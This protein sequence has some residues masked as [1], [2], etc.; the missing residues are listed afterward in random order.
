MKTNFKKG[1]LFAISV[2]TIASCSEDQDTIKPIETSSTNNLV[3]Y[4]PSGC[5]L[6]RSFGDE[7]KPRMVSIITEDGVVMQ[8]AAQR[9]GANGRYLS[10]TAGL[11]LHPADAPDLIGEFDRY[12][13]GVSGLLTVGDGSGAGINQ[14]GGRVILDFSEV[15]S[16]TMKNMLFTDIDENE[17]GSK[18][19][20]YSNAGQLLMQ[21][22]L[23]VTGDKGAAFVGFNNQPGVA[24]IIVTFG[25]ERSQHG[26]GTIARLQMCVEGAGRC[27]SYC[28]VDVSSMW[29][30][31]T[32]NS[33]TNVKVSTRNGSASEVLYKGHGLK[34]GTM[35]KVEGITGEALVLETNRKEVQ[36]INLA[37]EEGTGI[38]KNYGSFKVIEA[39]GASS[40][41]ICLQD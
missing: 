28:Y 30:Q 38:Q 13:L 25:A 21:Q 15:G 17:K 39:R 14:S 41:P 22:E 16:V 20:L 26:S 5:N 11:L 1:L 23:R 2:F 6:I 34:P 19:E 31:Y 8:V 37:C 27:D 7:I 24:K 32:G 9:R 12:I 33:V 3:G 40:Y 4:D 36:T 10:E 18:V 35:F 29:F